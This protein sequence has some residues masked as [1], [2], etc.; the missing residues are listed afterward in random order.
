MQ[1]NIDAEINSLCSSNIAVV[2]VEK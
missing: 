1:A 2:I